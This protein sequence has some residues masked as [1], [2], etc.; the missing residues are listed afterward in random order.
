MDEGVDVGGYGLYEMVRYN[1]FLTILMNQ[2]SRGR[3]IGC[4]FSGIYRL[5]WC[6][7][8]KEKI[9]ILKIKRE[10]RGVYVV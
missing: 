9:R 10:E 7:M 4:N 3:R 1:G 6:V 2:S 8:K 5:F